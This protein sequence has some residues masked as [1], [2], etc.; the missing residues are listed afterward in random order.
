MTTS[1]VEKCQNRLDIPQDITNI[2][3]VADSLSDWLNS[4]DLLS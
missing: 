4:D 1:T 3:G 2:K